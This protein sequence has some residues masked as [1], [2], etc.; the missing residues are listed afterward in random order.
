MITND[1]IYED[2]C[3]KIEHLVY[4]P[5]QEISESEL[6]R[7]YG[8]S[9]HMVRAALSRLRNRR[10]VEI[11]PQRGTYVSLIDLDYISDIMYLRESIE[12]EAVQRI[13][14]QGNQEDVCRRMEGFIAEQEKELRG[15]NLPTDRFFYLDNEFHWCLLK[16][17]GVPGTSQLI[18][19]LYIHFRRWRN[20]EL[21]R[22]YRVAGLIDQHREIVRCLRSG[23]RKATRKVLHD[24][25]NTVSIYETFSEED[26]NSYFLKNRKVD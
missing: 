5:G 23:D 16:G 8:A 13:I 11:Y 14:D 24:H 21:G 7:Q 2:L 1:E 25:I 26:K 3:S 15:Q 17:A 10:L 19:E 18:S 4:L 12:Q 22:T 9:R 20:L 6:C